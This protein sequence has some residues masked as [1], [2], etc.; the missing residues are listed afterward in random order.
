IDPLVIK[1]LKKYP[2]ELT[3]SELNDPRVQIIN[4]DG[5]LFLK[6]NQLEYDLILIGLSSPSDLSTNRFFT[7][8][9][10]A[11]VKS[12]LKP[13]G[14]V[15]FW[16]PGSLTYLSSEL[17][18]LN[19]C[20]L[21]TLNQVYE[22]VRIIPG[23]HNIYIA[24]ASGDI[25]NVTPEAIWQKINA[26]K[27]Q[28][29]TFTSS[30]LSYRLKEYWVDW[31][32]QSLK[33]APARINRD[34][35]PLA[36]FKMMVFWNKKFSPGLSSALERL[37]SLNLIK[38]LILAF[39]ATGLI[40]LL[41]LRR[42]GQKIII[43]SAIA[44][45]GF[46]G[47]LANLI[48]IFSYQIYYG[49]LYH[50]IGL[51]ISLF[52]AGTATGSILITSKIEKIK[53]LKE[54]FIIVEVMIIVFTYLMALILSRLQWSGGPTALLFISLFFICGLFLGLE[55]PLAGKIYL[56]KAKGVGGVAGMLYASDLIGGWVAG[57]FAGIIF[58][59]VLGLF[60][61]CMVIII[62]KTASL[63]LLLGSR[64]LSKNL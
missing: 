22:R 17:K 1:I 2:T 12:R 24:S 11:L 53:R 39:A 27:I 52:M 42:Q 32:R 55:F 51:L 37:E 15:A 49:Y 46:F 21:D 8:E 20:I 34:L 19:S 43:T 16:L 29:N 40:F 44:T 59:P 13:Q 10:F 56:G 41:S 25:M 48:L 60:N 36:V 57:I 38:I 23:E 45:T 64:F 7:K 54:L 63:I 35:Q 5:R 61:T 9:F 18:G 31:F 58:L 30:Y 50:R 4:T 28:T 47:M 3:R 62:V 6:S 26:Q 33:G 14:I